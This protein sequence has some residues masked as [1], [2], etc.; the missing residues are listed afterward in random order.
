MSNKVI[1]CYFRSTIDLNGITATG[2]VALGIRGLV[3]KNE[4]APR[5]RGAGVYQGN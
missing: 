1:K 2:L 4:P 3:P 5:D